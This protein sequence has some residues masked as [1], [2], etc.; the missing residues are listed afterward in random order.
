MSAGPPTKPIWSQSNMTTSELSQRTG[1]PASTLKVWV[2]EGLLRPAMAGYG[3][4]ESHV[5]DEHNV[6]QVHA[7]L[8]VRELFG[9]SKAARKVLTDA[10]PQIRQGTPHLRVQ[11][12][13]LEL[14]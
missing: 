4:G 10:I 5:F 13:V 9:D 8:K 6:A 1:V 7:I 12:F 11:E 14:A 3:R 2:R